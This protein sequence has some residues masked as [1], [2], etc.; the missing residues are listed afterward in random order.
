MRRPRS[1]LE[2]LRLQDK[3]GAQVAT[4]A[5]PAGGVVDGEIPDRDHDQA[6]Q[7]R[8]GHADSR[9]LK[10]WRADLSA[11]DLQADHDQDQQ[12]D[13]Y[14]ETPLVAQPENHEVR[15]AGW[16][17][18][19]YA[20][21]P[22]AAHV[23]HHEDGH[24]NDCTDNERPEARD[25]LLGVAGAGNA[26]EAKERVEA[27]L[28]EACVRVNG[29]VTWDTEANARKVAIAVATKRNGADRGAIRDALVVVRERLS[30][31]R[32]GPA[33]PAAQELA[34]QPNARLQ[35]GDDPNDDLS[36]DGAGIRGICIYP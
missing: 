1:T 9:H 35:M 33:P 2:L 26:Q 27:A 22:A 7:R 4:R 23:D 18:P 14:V 28:W 5:A 6:D 11:S 32:L 8:G 30:I 13:Y 24:K 21:H 10:A 36:S 3:A 20:Q 15:V 29:W 31:C 17:I 34:Q 16:S 19:S 25:E 12:Y